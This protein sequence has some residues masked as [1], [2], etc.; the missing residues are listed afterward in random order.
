MPRRKRTKSKFMLQQGFRSGLEEE[1]GK[2]L[3]RRGI[4]Y[5]FENRK[6]P[7]LK[8]HHSAV[9]NECGSEDISTNHTYTP[10]FYLPDYDFYIE[11]KGRFLGSDRRK[12]VAFR[13]SNP[14]VD[15]RFV[16]QKE[17]YLTI[18]KKQTYTGWCESKGYKYFVIVTPTKKRKQQLLP[19]EWFE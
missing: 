2:E 14:E 16:F 13:K 3:E 11:T 10:D 18:K 17:D 12:H 19:E 9:C 6:L 15:I 7:F 5:E 1:M 8:P 4:R